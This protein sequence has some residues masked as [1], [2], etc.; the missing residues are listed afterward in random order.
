MLIESSSHFSFLRVVSKILRQLAICTMC[1]FTLL[2]LLLFPFFCIAQ[3]QLR[4]TVL[5]I[6]DK[7]PIPY[8]NIVPVGRQGGTYS[9]EKGAFEIAITD[10][11]SLAFSSVGYKRI[12]LSVGDI[13]KLNGHIHLYP[14]T[15]LLQ[16]TTITAKRGKVK[17]E[18]KK[19]GYLKTNRRYMV[20]SAIP[21]SQNAVFIK[22]NS[23]QEGLIQFVQLGIG[24]KRKSKIRIRLYEPTEENGVGK[25]ITR[26]N[27]FADVTGNHRS[28]KID[29]SM[30]Q[31]IFPEKG[32]VVA[33]ESL[34]EVDKAGKIKKGTESTTTLF[35]TNGKDAERNTWQAYRDRSFKRERFND[36]WKVTANAVIGL[37]V[38]FFVE[39]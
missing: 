28:F 36:H 34:G 23:G 37:S 14:E 20:D 22:N 12:T 5:S 1:R 19:F 35:L 32:I 13:K 33:V 27:I 39:D 15:I 17:P 29:V 18:I 16:G 30:H 38:I 24:A 31:I 9:D 25:E 2:F 6:D 10:K 21:G 8:A 3:E 4:G 26:Q 11:D 7:E